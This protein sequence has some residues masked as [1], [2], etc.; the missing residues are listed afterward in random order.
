[1]TQQTAAT[2]ISVLGARGL[3]DTDPKELEQFI[4][5]HHKVKSPIYMHLLFAIGTILAA[6]FFFASL[7]FLIPNLLFHGHFVSG[8][9]FVLL[10]FFLYGSSQRSVTSSRIVLLQFSFIFMIIGKSLFTYGIAKIIGYAWG[11]SLGGLAIS[12]ATYFLYKLQIERLIAVFLVLY[13]I[14]YSVSRTHIDNVALDIILYLFL[15][16]QIASLVYLSF[17]PRL[18]RHHV[19]VLYGV[20]FS[21]IAVAFSATSSLQV[22]FVYNLKILNVTIFSLLMTAG[23]IAAILWI[24]KNKSLNWSAKPVILSIVTAIMLGFLSAPGIILSTLIVLLGYANHERVL[25]AI[26]VLS[27][28][29]F[30]SI[31]YY[32]LDITLIEKSIT[33]LGSGGLFLLAWLYVARKIDMRR[34]AT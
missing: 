7:H 9:I 8:P 16:L 30:M 25:A 11:A 4:V 2:L 20:L 22:P 3:L 19:P 15:F 34:Q 21:L 6:V 5:A 24:A 28:P 26:G 29:I 23:L 33:L 27:L 31:F 32:H 10:A 18:D 13:S 1:M 12:A 17:K 14:F